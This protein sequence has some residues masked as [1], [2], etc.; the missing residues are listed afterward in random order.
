MHTHL[1]QVVL[2]VQ[3]QHVIVERTLEMHFASSF[4]QQ[5]WYEQSFDATDVVDSLVG[6]M[7]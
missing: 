1:C 5:Q 3:Q 2:H 7:A 6:R 4:E